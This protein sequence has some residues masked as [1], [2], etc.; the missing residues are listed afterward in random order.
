[1]V[2]LLAAAACSGSGSDP[3]VPTEITLNSTD[4]TLAAVG[5]NLQLTASVL[6]Q[7]GDPIP[8]A[9]VTWE[10]ADPAIVSV[11]GTGLLIAQAPGT[12][13]VTATAG[14]AS[15]TATVI[16]ASTASLAL[17][18]GNG[19]TAAS[20]AAVPTAPAVRVRNASDAPVSGVQVRFQVGSASGTVTGETQ[21]TGADGV[22]RVGSWRL[23]SA[24]VNTLTATVEGAQ[25][26]GEP[27]E[28]IA[29]TA[30]ASGYNITIRYLSDL[31][32]PQ[33]LAFAEAEL[34]WEDFV[35]GDLTDVN[36][37]LPANSCGPNPETPGPFDDLTIF[38]TIEPIDGPFGILG[39]AGPCFIRDPG[40]LTVIGRM[41]FDSDDMELLETEGSLPAVILHEMGH[42]LG[43]GTLWINP[44]GLVQ[45][46]SDPDPQPPLADTHFTGAQAIAAFNA[47]GGSSYT[48]AKVPVMNVGGAGTVNSHWRDEVFNPELMTGFLEQGV[49]V[50][51]L[52]AISVRS[53]QD[54]GYTV[55]VADADPFTLTPAIRVA[56]Q[57]RGRQLINDIISDP[58]RRITADG[59][60][61]G[62][63]QR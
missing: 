33:L 32:N 16:V 41:Q 34:R 42:V 59:R 50:F 55:S 9:P 52:S 46:P 37:T 8:D 31:T 6:D 53:L 26:A 39:Q 22:A 4:V 18:E 10:S 44:F 15:S 19:Q 20:G 21:T 45:D 51:P 49:S 27:V 48:G 62:V 29:T 13:E 47:A 30:D 36:E 1:L 25:L 38:V 56:G 61:V 54:M 57:R 3:N 28:F 5:Q 14:E 60:V 58:I 7:D 2:L 24:G 63:I 35:T 11:S 23:G 17:H 12:A 43:F 40:D